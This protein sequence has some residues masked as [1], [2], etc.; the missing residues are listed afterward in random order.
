[1]GGKTKVDYQ[2]LIP[3]LEQWDMNDPIADAAAKKKLG[4]DFRVEPIDS[5]TNAHARFDHFVMYSRMIWP[6]F[7]EHDDCVFFAEG[8][9]AKS[10]EEW[11]KQLN[12]TRTEAMLNHR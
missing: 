12:K 4:I 11:R 3:E 5:W 10:Y 7:K 1:M 8:F 6:E 2:K 9:S